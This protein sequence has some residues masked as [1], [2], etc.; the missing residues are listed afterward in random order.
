VEEI[1]KVWFEESEFVDGP[2]RSLTS[3]PFGIPILS[4]KETASPVGEVF[5]EEH[6][7]LRYIES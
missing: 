4:K 1:S 3:I 5:C 6:V 2:P 7:L